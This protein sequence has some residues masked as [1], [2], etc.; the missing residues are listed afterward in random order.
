M[1]KTTA[2]V[3]RRGKRGL[4]RRH[5]SLQHFQMARVGGIDN[6]AQVN[7]AMRLTIS[8]HPVSVCNLTLTRVHRA[9]YDIPDNKL[10]TLT[11]LE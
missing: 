3:S 6:I 1:N 4:V 7:M 9:L 2:S 11:A 5:L 10:F 8:Q